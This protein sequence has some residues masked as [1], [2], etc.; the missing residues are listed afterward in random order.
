MHAKVRPNH[1][2]GFT[3]VELLVVI[4]IIAVLIS[5]LLPA[6]SVVRE[7]AHKVR[8]TS[9]LS[10]LG[11]GLD[12]YKGELA[13]GGT[14]PPSRS[15]N[16]D[17]QISNPLDRTSA[18]D[19]DTP[20]TGAHLLVHAMVGADLIG[21]AGFKDLDRNGIWADDSHAA[22]GGIYEIDQASG[23]PEQTRYQQ[24]GYVDDKMLE[25]ITTLG[26]LADSNIIVSAS[27]G[28]N[29]LEQTTRDQYLFVDDWDHP[30]LYYKANP[31]ATLMVTDTAGGNPGVYNQ[32]DNDLLTGGSADG[33]DPLG[34]DFGYGPYVE[35]Q[36]IF[37][38]LAKDVAPPAVPA[39]QDPNEIYTQATYDNSFVRFIHDD[40]VRAR[41]TPVRRDSY[42][43]ISAGPDGVY[44]TGDDITNW[45][46]QD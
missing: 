30:I 1:K 18:V 20:V 12:M 41:N 24:P 2:A 10:S 11:V 42:L 3:L 5:I 32:A 33:T 34:L 36:Q 13:L 6:F 9:S 14:F 17:G 35:G 23:Q 28:Y 21:P 19:P 26:K 22:A 8:T 43:L 46:R 31:A 7:N 40:T 16:G 25:G 37:H 27:G 45:N 4:A 39:Q 38:A 44:G 15:D 29:A